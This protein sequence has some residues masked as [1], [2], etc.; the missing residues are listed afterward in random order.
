[1]NVE[2]DIPKCVASG[3]CVLI[4]PDVFDQDDDGMVILLDSNPPSHLHDDTREAAMVCPAAAI[5][6][7]EN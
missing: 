2:V 6:T 5:H 4:A 3:Q 1:M 7:K